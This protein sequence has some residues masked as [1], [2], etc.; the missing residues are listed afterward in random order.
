MAG[1]RNASSWRPYG[2]ADWLGL[3]ASPTFALAA[4]ITAGDASSMMIC[5]PAYDML[6]VDGMVLM[7]L[8]MSFFHLP[9]WL[10]LASFR[11]RRFPYPANQIEGE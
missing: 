11:S 2:L 7:Y 8:L 4:W 3:A 9:C 10:R 5:A 1:N 6:P